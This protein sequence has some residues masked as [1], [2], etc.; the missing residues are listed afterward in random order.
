MSMELFVILAASNAPDT[1]A[2]NRALAEAQVPARIEAADLTRHTGFL[3]VK[4]G[5]TQTGLRFLLESY[6]ELA[7]HYPAVA[8]L[9]VEK[10]VVY[11]LG[12]G[13]DWDECA[14]VFYSASVL[15]AKFG[16]TAFEPQGGIVM[17]SKDLLDAAGECRKEAGH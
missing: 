10:P 5:E 4:V 1:D 13:G 17:S 6:A 15:V 16:G 9:R 11:S 3:P 8:S 2:W 14:A 7:T 12:Y